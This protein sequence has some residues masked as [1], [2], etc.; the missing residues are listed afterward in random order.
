MSP[1]KKAQQRVAVSEHGLLPFAR[2]LHCSIEVAV[3]Y[4]DVA[5]SARVCLSELV[6][7]VSSS[8]PRPL[9]HLQTMVSTRRWSRVLRVAVEPELSA[10]YHRRSGV[11]AHLHWH[12]LRFRWLFPVMESDLR[13]RPLG[14]RTEL[15]LDAT[16]HPPGGIM[17]V[18]GD[19][20]VGRLVARSTTEAFIGRLARALE[21]AVAE[22][23][24]GAAPQHTRAGTTR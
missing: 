9:G 2:E 8:D 1:S 11:L 16:Y 3:P 24:C 7:E 18:L 17:G 23:R 19:V 5:R 10:S 4:E 13:A 14:P 12:A 6:T 15:V 22:G 21:D 20:L